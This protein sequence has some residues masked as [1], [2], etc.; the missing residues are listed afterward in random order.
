MSQVLHSRS[1]SSLNQS[2]RR[3]FKTGPEQTATTPPVNP[4][5]MDLSTTRRRFSPYQPP[6]TAEEPPATT[7]PATTEEPPATTE[8]PPATAEEPPATAEEPPATTEEP[9]ATATC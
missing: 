8:E 3:L 2:N 7:P 9:P 1:P 5:A 4:D 6:A